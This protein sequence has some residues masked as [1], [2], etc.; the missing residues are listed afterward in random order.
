MSIRKSKTDQYR[1]GDKIV[2]SKGESIACPYTKLQ[3]Y[4][5]IAGLS[6]IDDT[7]LL[8]KRYM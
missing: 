3:R 1:L 8:I 2:I 4:M 7:F 6:T 5:R